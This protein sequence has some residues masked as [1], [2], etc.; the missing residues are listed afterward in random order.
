[1][2]NTVRLGD[3]PCYLENVADGV[4]D[5]DAVNVRQLQNVS[6]GAYYNVILQF[7]NEETIKSHGLYILEDFDAIMETS[8]KEIDRWDWRDGTFN[9]D[10]AGT[11]MITATVGFEEGSIIEGYMQYLVNDDVVAFGQYFDIVDLDKDAH[12]TMASL[13]HLDVD[14]SFSVGLDIYGYGSSAG[15]TVLAGVNTQITIHLVTQDKDG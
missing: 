5:Y 6:G 1:M 2:T 10:I 7:E 4:E 3:S 8:S 15:G 12:V 11:Y 9:P 14:D 13:V